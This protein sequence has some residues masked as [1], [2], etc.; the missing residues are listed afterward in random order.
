M[1]PT[2]RQSRLGH[3]HGHVSAAR[4]AGL[5]QKGR[6]RENDRRLGEGLSRGGAATHAICATGP[7]LA[8]LRGKG[9]GP[10]GPGGTMRGR[11]ISCGLWLS[12]FAVV[13]KLACVATSTVLASTV[14][15]TST[16]LTFTVLSSSTLFVA[17]SAPTVAQ[18]T[19]CNVGE[20]QT[21]EQ[22]KT[23]E[24]PVS[25][26]TS[27]SIGSTATVPEEPTSA[28]LS[29]ARSAASWASSAFVGAMA[30]LQQSQSSERMWLVSQQNNRRAIMAYV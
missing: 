6:A 8:G 1:E 14:L 15:M 9:R 3:P 12:C 24:P 4:H 10:A 22:S 27:A 29:P 20:D 28:C 5:G 25:C 11:W 2:L 30:R 21:L 18:N 19:F 17:L 26:V 23:E 16:V 13:V 7:R